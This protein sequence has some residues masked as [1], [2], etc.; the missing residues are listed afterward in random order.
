MS[1]KEVKASILKA[2]DSFNQSINS[3]LIEAGKFFSDEVLM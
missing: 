3:A 1:E 2:V